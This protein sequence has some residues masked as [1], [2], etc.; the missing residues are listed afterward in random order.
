MFASAF[1]LTRPWGLHGDQDEDRTRI[2]IRSGQGPLV[3]PAGC[4]LSIV[5]QAGLGLRFNGKKIVSA[6]PE[7]GTFS[8]NGEKRYWTLPIGVEGDATRFNLLIDA[9]GASAE[10]V[11][12]GLVGAPARPERPGEGTL[13]ERLFGL[14]LALIERIRSLIDDEVGELEHQAVG[15]KLVASAVPWP[16]VARKWCEAYDIDHPPPLDVIVR[17]AE[18]LPRTIEALAGHPR[19]ILSR[20][21]E[22][23][24]VSRVQELDPACLAWYVRQPGSTTA[25]KAGARQTILAVSRQESFDT[26]ENRVLRAYLALAAHAARSYAELHRKLGTS[27]RMRIVSRY[28]RLSRRLE[29]D[30]AEAGIR[31]PSGPVVPNYVLSQDNRYRKVWDGY[32][33]LLRRRQDEDDVWRWQIRLWAECVRISVLV[34]LR[35]LPGAQIIAEAPVQI[36]ADQHRGRWADI[37]PHSAVV[38]LPVDARR[39]VVTVI[40]AQDPQAD[41]FGPRGLWP[42]LWSIGPGCV[43]HA[44]DLASGEETWV[45]VWSL[46]PIDGRSLDLRREA[47]SA[48]QALTRLI[49]RIRDDGGPA[50]R[51]RGVI[52]ASAQGDSK[53]IRVGD[54]GDTLAYH[55]PVNAE[56]LSGI[57]DSLADM[58]PVILGA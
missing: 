55:C 44:Q 54:Y 32:Q 7:G 35:R 58:L 22:R 43:L 9:E 27:E 52:L 1:A 38:S 40:D 31:P 42:Y 50:Y 10:T 16:V 49:R 51:L 13:G 34:A 2:E 6:Q 17:H 37:A 41:T 28:E 5:A 25:E 57:V 8:W 33:E 30:L 48:D 36:R 29:R 56:S 20:V 4:G 21:R 24:P 26:L 3:L 19:R 12:I 11:E 45:L 53:D 23:L 39:L 14:L 46:H 15:R 47:R 18:M